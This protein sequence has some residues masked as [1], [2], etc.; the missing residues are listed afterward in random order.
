VV[1]VS[2]DPQLLLIGHNSLG[3]VAVLRGDLETGRVHAE[4]SYRLADEHQDQDFMLRYGGDFRGY[5]RV[6]LSTAECLLGYPDRALRVFEET[7]QLTRDHPYTLGFMLTFGITPILRADL[8]HTLACAEQLTEV[9]ERHGFALLQ[10]VADIHRGWA[11]A[12]QGDPD[13]VG[14]I[15]GA[16]PVIKFVKLDSF[17]PMYLG[18]QAEAQLA[19]AQ[20]DE[21]TAS[22][23]EADEYLSAAGG[24]S[25]YAAEL[26]RLDGR[27]RA[28]RGSPEGAAE[29][30]RRAIA[31]ARRQGARWWELRATVALASLEQPT[32]RREEAQAL[33]ARLVESFD[34]GDATADVLAARAALNASATRQPTPGEP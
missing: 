14:Q 22:L 2:L 32:D 12:L 18:L 31:I 29:C 4:Q 25:F 26:S 10:L 20:L 9:S 24:E 30:T 21:A 7:L 1:A 15:A 27:L 23:A 28:L 19:T 13:G 6:W 34:E 17:L 3:L 11:R 5:P 33:L 8:Q 16:L